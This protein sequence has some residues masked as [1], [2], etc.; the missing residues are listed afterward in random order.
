[1]G[2]GRGAARKHGRREKRSSEIN[3]EV[4]VRLEEETGGVLFVVL[5]SVWVF[6]PV[7]FV[8]LKKIPLT[9]NTLS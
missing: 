6:S 3:R 5:V 9:V 2:S 8:F 1:L 7:F 4:N